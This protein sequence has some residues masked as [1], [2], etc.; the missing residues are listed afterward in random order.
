MK[1]R[2]IAMFLSICLVFSLI[3]VSVQ[4]DSKPNIQ[5]GDYVKMGTYNGKS[6]LWRCVSIDADGP[7]MLADKI[8]D[9]L[10]YDAKTN[11]NSNSKSHSRSY[12]RDSYGSNYWRDSNMRS[13]LNSTA[14]AGKVDWLCGNPPKDGY[15]SGTGAYNNKAG[16]LNE[17]SKAE[18]A[19]MKTVTQRSLVSHP[20]YNKG[21]VEGDANSDLLYYTDISEAVANYDSS[22]FETT[23]EK[24]FL[25]DVKQANA[26]WRNLKGYYVA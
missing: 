7:L 17:F 18:I 15:V 22:Y 1:R 24:V 26:V 4:A 2:L 20:E 13:W 19:A 11:D 25:L 10:A 16:F 23:T 5:I 3:P 8:V 6:I 12:K 14:T 9:T 21:I